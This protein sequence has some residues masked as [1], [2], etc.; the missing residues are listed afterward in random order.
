[1]KL[2]IGPDA[3]TSY[4][5]LAYSPWHALAEFVDNS[6]QSYFDNQSALDQQMRNE[7]DKVLTVAIVYENKEEYLRV[8][9]NAMG[10]SEAE[11]ER[12]LHVARPPENTSGR[13]KYG[14]GMKTAACWIGNKWRIITKKLGESV[15][16]SVTIDVDE[17]AKGRDQ[18]L[19]HTS[20]SKP[21]DRH[22]TIVEIFDLNRKFYGRTQGKIADFLRSMYRVDLQQERLHLFWR[23]QKLS[24]DSLDS[25]LFVARDGTKYRKNFNFTVEGKVVEGWVGI[26][27]KGSRA[28][29]GFSILQA[30]R[31]V[32]GWPDA[33]R[34]SSLYGQIQGSNDLVN[35]RLVG[36]IHLDGFEV[37]HTKDNILWR[38][39]Q[40][41]TIEKEMEQ[42][43]SDYRD[44]AKSRR[45]RKD[46]QRGPNDLV[47]RAALADLKKE[48]SSPDM[49]D[50]IDITTI[51]PKETIKANNGEII[52]SV[53]D[54]QS[55]TLQGTIKSNP[56][57]AW[58]IFLEDMS[59]ND[60][61]VISDST[62]KNQITV[63]VN[64]SHPYWSTQ[65]ASEESVRDYFRQCVY[66][67]VAEWQAREKASTVD[68]DT[69]KLLKD[70]LLRVP[71]AMESHTESESPDAVQ[72]EA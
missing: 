16:H 44:I 59:P 57:I 14:M 19:I 67:S 70:H 68:P 26:L 20:R 50:Q 28:D 11:L 61:Y 31:V 18:G 9:D 27:D 69:V 21:A 24:W 12:A 35:Q 65:L 54:T 7:E 17:V 2:I 8:S 48:L 43:C 34:P 39:N 72:L 10:M 47:V 3:I 41:E 1:M 42:Y 56:P 40:E 49:V 63:V 53:I 6:T 5:R 4:R 55:A 45:K 71:L 25:R 46:D 36:E 62:K 60:P 13:S 38:D 66:D 30:N 52:D 29:A 32:R 33:W 15:E 37:S 22:Y 64:T 51:P 23:E 58:K